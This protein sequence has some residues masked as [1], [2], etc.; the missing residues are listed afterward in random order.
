MVDIASGSSHL[1]EGIN[2]VVMETESLL[3]GE[4]ILE[5]VVTQ[6]MSSGPI[7]LSPSTPKVPAKVITSCSGQK[8]LVNE[9]SFK[10]ILSKK[11]DSSKKKKGV[12]TPKKRFQ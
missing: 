11:K 5:Q 10:T 2:H 7:N 9:D 8:M 1:E 4:P 3:L 6:D 12:S